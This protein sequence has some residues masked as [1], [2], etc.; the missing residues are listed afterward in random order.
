MIE[1]VPIQDNTVCRKRHKINIHLHYDNRLRDRD[2]LKGW[3]EKKLKT[4]DCQ[5]S[6][7]I[8]Y[9]RHELSSSV[10]SQIHLI[11]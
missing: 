2:N 1:G 9:G 5:Q 6:H 10:R 8:G 4:G 7:V 11:R 3:E